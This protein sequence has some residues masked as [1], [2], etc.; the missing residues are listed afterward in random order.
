MKEKVIRMLVVGTA[1]SF[2][3]RVLISGGGINSPLMP[4]L[5]LMSAD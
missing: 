3:Q 4:V 1:C 2:D 5:E